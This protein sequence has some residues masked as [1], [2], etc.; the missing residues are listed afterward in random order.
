MPSYSRVSLQTVSKAIVAESSAPVAGA[1]SSSS[2]TAELTRIAVLR[3][4]R[5]SLVAV[6]LL[7]ST[8][9]GG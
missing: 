4:C 3:H 6:A 7:S 8:G 5:H 2:T 1:T 9:L